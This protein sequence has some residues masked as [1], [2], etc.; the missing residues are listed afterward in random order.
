MRLLMIHSD[1]MEYTALEP[2]VKEPEK[3][4]DVG[5]THRVEECLVTFCSV[6]K[7]DE[8]SPPEI[9]KHAAKVILEQAN[10]V[11]AER[12]LL[13][14][15]AHLSADLASP[16]G[17]IKTLIL[18]ERA[19]KGSVEVVRAP[20][21]WYKSF[22]IR[23]KGHPLGELARTVT[24]EM[25]EEELKAEAEAKAEEAVAPS[26]FLVLTPEGSEIPIDLSEPKT[27]SGLRIDPPLL[28]LINNEAG[29][30]G[31]REAP[32][33]IRIMKKLELVDYEPA[34]DVGHFRFYPKGTIIK[35]SLEEFAYNIAVKDLHAFKIETPYLYRLDEP[36]I[37]EQA[38]K[39]REKDY[40]LRVDNREFTLRFAGDFGLFRMMKEVIMS[41]KQLPIRVYELSP[42]FRLEQ[43]G[44]CVGL[45][46]MRSFTMPDLHCFCLNLKQ[47]M[48]EYME[49]CKNYTKLTESMEIDY[50]VAFRVV[51]DFYEK[52]KEWFVSLLKVVNKPALIE[53]MPEMKHYWV[54]KNEYQAIDAAG[55][56]T[57]LVTVQLDI[58]DAARYGIFYTDEKGQKKGCIIL[59]SSLGSIERWMGS[60]LEQAVKDQMR[61][62]T[63]KLPVW[64]SPIQVRFLP[65][66]NSH[67]NFALDLASKVADQG[68]RVD[69]DDREESVSKK[70]R[71]AEVE[72]IPYIVVVGER[73]VSSGSLP[74]RVRG[75]ELI[76]T[77]LEGL[78]SL[79]KESL[80]DRPCIPSYL[81]LLL[82]LKPR[83]G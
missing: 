23:C 42:S 18:L 17:A 76:N 67:L 49:L 60:I 15:Y 14:P 9:A 43:S 29:I 5:K 48:S 28:Q 35:D 81:P 78:I 45:K 47:G 11:K 55:G 4:E 31:G 58:E 79:V 39:F 21:G 41:Y 24:L 52:N 65:V 16:A 32:G 1:Y 80:G 51:K 12:V 46:R 30:K 68:L 57:Q 36:D 75:G 83:F 63:P 20:F 40:R 53:E 54:L 10:M 59:H 64:L 62:K 3:I 37:A 22:D 8:S 44:E 50:A 70:I 38:S 34:S 7:G 66:K 61:G 56:N 82:S 74:V 13:Y 73:E 26:I 19:L 71:D 69:V 25:A 72:W 6:E 2:A 77:H 33:H 27:F